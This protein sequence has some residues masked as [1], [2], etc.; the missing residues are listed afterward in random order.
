MRTAHAQDFEKRKKP[1]LGSTTARSVK[2]DDD[3]D[4]DDDDD[5]EQPS[6]ESSASRGSDAAAYPA[7]EPAVR[8]SRDIEEARDDVAIGK[9]EGSSKGAYLSK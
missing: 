8:S 7:P 5:E 3:S 1:E 6:G 9:G 2:G 4:D